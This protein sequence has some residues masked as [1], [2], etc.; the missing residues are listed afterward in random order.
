MRREEDELMPLAE[1]ALTTDDWQRIYEAFREN[2]NPL[3]GLKPKDDAERLYQRILA[4][5]PSP[6]GYARR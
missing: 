1:R 2:D 3:Y 4:L 5:A 6:I